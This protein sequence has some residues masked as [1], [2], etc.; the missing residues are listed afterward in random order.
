MT[1]Q[2]GGVGWWIIREPSIVCPH[3]FKYLCIGIER[4]ISYGHIVRRYCLRPLQFVLVNLIK[5]QINTDEHRFS[6]S[7]SAFIGVRLRLV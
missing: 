4:A 7:V 5:P 6:G 2:H 1:Q 3:L